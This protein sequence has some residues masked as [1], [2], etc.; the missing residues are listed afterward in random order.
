LW[1][2]EAKVVAMASTV[3]SPMPAVPP[4]MAAVNGWLVKRE[5]VSRTVVMSII[6]YKSCVVQG[7]VLEWEIV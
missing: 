6:L 2:E 5:F 1:P 3:F 7:I 4:M